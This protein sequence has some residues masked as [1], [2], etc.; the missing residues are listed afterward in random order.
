MTAPRQGG[1]VVGR[2]VGSA[3]G[4][5][6]VL[7]APALGVVLGVVLGIWSGRD[8]PAELQAATVATEVSARTVIV[9]RR[10]NARTFIRISL[11]GSSFHCV[12]HRPTG[13][14]SRRCLKGSAITE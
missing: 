2:R 5:V 9:V 12:G 10:R 11:V 7:A 4:H 14:G 3:V 13:F 1:P 8:G 6:G